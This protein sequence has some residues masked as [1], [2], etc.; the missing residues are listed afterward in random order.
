[1]TIMRRLTTLLI[2]SSFSLPAWSGTSGPLYYDDDRDHDATLLSWNPNYFCS[3][4]ECGSTL[5]VSGGA[6]GGYYE[7]IIVPFDADD[8]PTGEELPTDSTIT[9]AIFKFYV[10]GINT[11]P[12]TIQIRTLRQ[13]PTNFN[14]PTWN[15]YDSGFLSSDEW[16][17]NTQTNEAH[18]SDSDCAGEVVEVVIP[19]LLAGLY[20]VDVTALLDNGGNF[21]LGDPPGGEIA[22]LL[23]LDDTP[24][25]GL[26]LQ[27]STD[28]VN[29]FQLEFEWETNTPTPTPT[30]TG[31][32]T[33]TRTNTPTV[34]NT[35]TKTNT[36][37]QTNTPTPFVPT[38]TGTPTPTCAAEGTYS[39]YYDW[40][41]SMQGEL[42]SNTPDTHVSIG[43]TSF[44][45]WNGDGTGSPTLYGH[46]VINF[47]LPLTAMPNNSVIHSAS[48]YMYYRSDDLNSGPRYIEVRRTTVG[49]DTP[50]WNEFDSVT[51]TAW[52]NAAISNGAH[53]GAPDSGAEYEWA[54]LDTWDQTYM[55]DVT[56]MV[57]S[58][59]SGS[60]TDY[61]FL[62]RMLTYRPHDASRFTGGDSSSDRPHLVIRYCPPEVVEPEALEGGY[63]KSLFPDTLF[64]LTDSMPV[65]NS[66]TTE[67]VHVV[68]EFNIDGNS[69]PTGKVISS[70]YLELYHNERL[71][72]QMT[73]EVRSID[74]NPDDPTWNESDSNLNTAWDD[75]TVANVAHSNPPDVERRAW[76]A[77]IRLPGHFRWYIKDLFPGTWAGTDV[78]LPLLLR[79]YEPS[80]VSG[81]EEL[82]LVGPESLANTPQLK[83]SYRDP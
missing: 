15:E 12:L 57:D 47:N 72:R 64:P 8:L 43:G 70:A 5:L 67:F 39:I 65:I 36:P 19:T 33:P 31:S 77:G 73:V 40:S 28:N 3:L 45:V 18:Y 48:L 37:T 61:S 17:N 78:S 9:S 49:L 1:M 38:P 13:S 34:T 23:R 42:D 81:R 55:W 56:E 76:R 20:E 4:S 80:P 62:V 6:E 22:F 83:L 7:H 14:D 2:I 10:T 24:D 29:R 66:D 74:V 68:M 35:P 60:A 63:L 30:P 82:Y 44:A 79:I 51:P 59:W 69:I 26:S 54:V 71:D 25:G 53:F 50:T 58:V 11:A 46:S 75:A 21:N 27:A 16:G 41:G 52:S 32:P